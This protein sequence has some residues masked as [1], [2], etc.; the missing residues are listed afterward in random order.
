M[1]PAL[2]LFL[3]PCSSIFL[4]KRLSSFKTLNLGRLVDGMVMVW[5]GDW[6]CG[7]LPKNCRVAPSPLRHVALLIP[8]RCLTSGI[9]S[10]QR[11]TLS[12]CLTF[13]ILLR[14][15]STWMSH[16]RNSS[17]PSFHPDVSHLESSPPTFHS[18][19]SHPEFCPTNVLPYPDVSHLEFSSTVIPPGCLTS[20]IL[21]RCHSTRVSHIRIRPTF[22]LLRISHIRNSVRPM[23]HLL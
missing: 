19:V 5:R 22:N 17:P 8:L 9:L 21:L 14:R 3:F 4:W 10:G 11:S 16:I 18:D 2:F 1:L 13:G 7:I 6:Q 12:G 20:K 23:F 15:H